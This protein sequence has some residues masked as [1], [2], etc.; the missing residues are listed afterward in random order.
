MREERKLNARLPLDAL[1]QKQPIGKV[2]I[3]QDIQIVELNEKRG[4]SN[5]GERNVTAFQLGEDRSPL[6][7][8]A[9]GQPGFPNHLIE[10]SARI[11]GVAWGELLERAG[12][13]PARFIRNPLFLSFFCHV[14]LCAPYTYG[15]P[16]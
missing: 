15:G 7:A 16:E 1:E 10:K 2:R 12:K 9:F 11:E 5:P 13:A 4:M 3:H 14:R 8:G 6:L